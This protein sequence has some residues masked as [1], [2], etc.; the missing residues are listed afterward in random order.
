I[1]SAATL[2]LSL[3]EYGQNER[4]LFTFLDNDTQKGINGFDRQKNN[5]YSLSHV[6]DYLNQSLHS[7]IRSKVNPDYSKWAAIRIA[8]ERTE[9]EFAYKKHKLYF[10]IIKTIGLLNIFSSSGAKLD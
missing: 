10:R 2:A 1:L 3:Q 7:I 9:G 4:S 6:Y 5:F 8:L